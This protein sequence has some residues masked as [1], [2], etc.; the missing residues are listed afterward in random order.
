LDKV[1]QQHWR[2]RPYLR[3][4]QTRLLA[5]AAATYASDSCQLP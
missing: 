2:V 1:L 4:S 5:A 3:T